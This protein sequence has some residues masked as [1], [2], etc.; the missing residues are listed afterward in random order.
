MYIHVCH[1]MR[2]TAYYVMY[3]IIVIKTHGQTPDN[4]ILCASRASGA[5]LEG[6]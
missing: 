6:P 1:K 3:H 5:R 4:P 2:N